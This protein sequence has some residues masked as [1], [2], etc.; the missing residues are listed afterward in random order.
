MHAAIDEVVRGALQVDQFLFVDDQFFAQST[1]L[2]G[3]QGLHGQLQR[4]GFAAVHRGHAPSKPGLDLVHGHED[5]APG[6]P[7]VTTFHGPVG[8]G[9]VL[10]Q[11][12]WLGPE[13]GAHI[14]EDGGPVKVACE[15]QER[16]GGSV[17][18]V[19]E[20][21]QRGKGRI[22][23]IA[24]RTNGAS[25]VS[26]PVKTRAKHGLHHHVV[27]VRSTSVHFVS[28]NGHLGAQVLFVERCV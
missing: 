25:A 26:V 15:E 2:L 8:G 18:L 12:G 9:D 10:V 7:T 20:R 24:G 22:F 11:R 16:V 14:I 19:V 4:D 17:M 28:H 27:G 5:V 13:M 3:A 6:C 21:T 1:A 23:H